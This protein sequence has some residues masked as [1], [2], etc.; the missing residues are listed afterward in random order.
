M[1]LKIQPYQK[2]IL[3]MCLTRPK[4]TEL[5]LLFANPRMP[6]RAYI[7][8]KEAFRYVNGEWVELV[9]L[10]RLIHNPIGDKL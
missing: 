9:D 5:K 3:N 6:P 7:D 10:P 2:A 8:G 4:G 1:K